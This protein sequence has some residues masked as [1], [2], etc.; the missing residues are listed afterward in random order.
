MIKNRIAPLKWFKRPGGDFYTVNLPNCHAT[1]VC[2]DDTS[3]LIYR[4]VSQDDIDKKTILNMSESHILPL[5]WE[6]GKE[7]ILPKFV[8]L[9]F[10]SNFKEVTSLA[11]EVW[12]SLKKW[13]MRKLQSLMSFWLRF[14][15]KGRRWH[16][17]NYT[18]IF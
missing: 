5:K 3:R 14:K 13:K 12:R 10:T 6:S 7:R 16:S 9:A 8:K 4:E 11:S 2:E 15:T 17:Y 1:L 18:D